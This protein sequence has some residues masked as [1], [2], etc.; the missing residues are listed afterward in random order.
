MSIDYSTFDPHKSIVPE[1][2][3]CLHDLLSCLDSRSSLTWCCVSVLSV[4]CR[5]L[6]ARQALIHTYQ[7]I[8]PLSRLIGDHLTHDRKVKLLTLMQELSFGIKMTWQIPHLP[9]LMSTL[10]KWIEVGEEE[11]VVLSLGVLVNLCYKNLPAIYTL[12]R[13]TDIK[14]FIR[15]CMSKKVS[16]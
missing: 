8:P 11:I 16:C 9:H 14:R 13:S 4:A 10:T 12:T 1:F 15:L 2:F 5:N 6:V 7:F 3:I